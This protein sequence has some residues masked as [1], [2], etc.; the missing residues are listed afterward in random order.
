MSLTIQ[1]VEHIAQLARLEL[2]EEEIN[3][4]RQQLSAVLD[5]IT[6]LQELDTTAIP[7]TSS[8]LPSRTPLRPDIPRPGLPVEDLLSNAPLTSDR[9]FRVP[10][11]LE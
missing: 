8:V 1:E 10:P 6:R 11:V 9:Q 7:P 3:L 5:Y 2:T 4:Y